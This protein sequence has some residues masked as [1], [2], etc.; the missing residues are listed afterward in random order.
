MKLDGDNIHKW[1]WNHFCTQSNGFKYCYIIVI[2]N[3]SH[4]LVH[5][6]WP[7]DSTQ[8][9]APTP[10]QSGTKSYGNEGVLH[11]HQISKDGAL[12]WDSLMSY[13]GH[14]SYLSAEIQ[15]V[16][17]IALADEAGKW[18]HW[19]CLNPGWSCLHFTLCK[20]HSERHDSISLQL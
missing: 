2:I 17:S 7:I 13:P 14:L 3:I 12:P 8:S 10:G 18:N 11:I 5:I 20:F 9:G 1:T 16:Y 4:L 15:S 19:S 6:V